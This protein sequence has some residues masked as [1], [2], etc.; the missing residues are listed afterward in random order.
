M[1]QFTLIALIL[2]LTGLLAA[3]AGGGEEATAGPATLLSPETP[4]AYPV[5]TAV[6]NAD[7]AYPALAATAVIGPAYPGQSD[8]NRLPPQSAPEGGN[9]ETLAAIADLVSQDLAKRLSLEVGQ[10]TVRSSEEVQWSDSSLGCPAPGF[11]Y[12]QV[13]T[14]GYKITLEADGGLYEYHTDLNQG[15]VLCGKDGQPVG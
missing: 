9:P 10:I 7:T 6:P 1:K 11:A 5:V 2:V 8:P 15:F 4:A 3:C 12:M 14:P 13:I